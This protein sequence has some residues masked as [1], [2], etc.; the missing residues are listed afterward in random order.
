MH[1]Q[2]NVVF[3]SPKGGAA[4]V[5]QSSVENFKDDESVRFLND[6]KKAQELVRNTLKLS[7]VK[8]ADYAAVLVVGGHGPMIDLAVDQGFAQLLQDVSGSCLV[9]VP[10][11]GHADN[12]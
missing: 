2:F 12:R 10:V 3:A 1:E 6:D 9:H 4:P 5:D 11:Y 8:A 7:D